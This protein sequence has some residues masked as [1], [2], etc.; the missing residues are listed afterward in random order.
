MAHDLLS[1]APVLLVLQLE[2]AHQDLLPAGPVVEMQQLLPL[3]PVLLLVL[4]LE[5][6][7]QDLVLHVVE[8]H[9]QL[10]PDELLL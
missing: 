5:M 3:P 4:Q 8:M 6:A 2:M 10:R 1:A 9:Q 7:Q